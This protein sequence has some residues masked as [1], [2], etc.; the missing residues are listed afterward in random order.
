MDSRRGLFLAAAGRCAC[1]ALG[2]ARGCALRARHR[3]GLHLVARDDRRCRNGGR[4]HR[5]HDQDRGRD[6]RR[7]DLDHQEPEL[8]RRRSGDARVGGGRHRDRTPLGL[9]VQ[10]VSRRLAARAAR[11]RCD[12]LQ[13]LQRPDPA[14]RRRRHLRLHRERRDR[15]RRR[16][17]RLHVRGRRRRAVGREQLGRPDRQPLAQRRRL[18]RRRVDQLHPGHRARAQRTRP[19]RLPQQ[20]QRGRSGKRGRRRSRGRGRLDRRR[21]RAERAGLQ[22]REARRL[23]DH[24]PAQRARRRGERGGRLRL[25]GGHAYHRQPDRR[26]GHGNSDLRRQRR[27]AV[28][29]HGGR[30]ERRRGQRARLDHRGARGRPAVRGRCAPG[31]GRARGDDRPAQLD[32]TARGRGRGR[33]GGRRGGPRQRHR[34]AL[35][36]RQVADAQRRHRDRADRHDPVGAPPVQLGRLHAPAQLGTGRPRR[37]R[38]RHDRRA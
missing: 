16:R 36:P 22:R 13:R 14:A 35:R 5:R 9:G 28:G 4:A 30:R 26:L 11:G 7:V 21:D 34:L 31:A 10:P 20:H 2:R 38:G 23:H 8:R 15:R 17:H 1:R 24:D 33:R 6:L 25:A 19:L 29:R 3:A 37:S 12:K 32:R 18:P 27:G